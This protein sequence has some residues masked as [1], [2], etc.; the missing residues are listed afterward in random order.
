V[1]VRAWVPL[2]AHALPPSHVDHAENVVD[3]QPT[4][5]S[6]NASPGHAALAPVQRSSTSQPPAAAPRQTRLG[7]SNAQV[8]STAAPCAT[9]Q[10]S[11][12]PLHAEL[13]HTPSAQL[14]ELHSVAAAH[15]V[16][17]V[18]FAE[19]YVPLQYVLVAQPLV[20]RIGQSASVPLHS[21][22]AP[23]AGV[24]GSLT[25]AGVQLPA[26]AVRLQRSQL[27]LHALLQ[28]NP[29]A[30]KPELHW[31]LAVQA[32]PICRSGW[33]WPVSQKKPVVQLRVDEHEVGHAPLTPS[34]VYEPHW[35]IC[36]AS[37]SGVHRPALPAAVHVSHE[38]V[39]LPPQHTPPTQK[40]DAQSVARLHELPFA[41]RG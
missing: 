18:F 19:Q 20:Q 1:R 33:H 23:Q 4:P 2:V 5:A 12:A 38:P 35:V 13:Q 36:V 30:Q 10:A 28:H 21:T 32:L 37:A 41:A 11:H 7:P 39:Q 17:L 24:P 9:L 26:E 27:P 8:P 3:P 25:G 34:Q 40:P 15:A 16:P 29:S 31:E 6:A 22:I 14:L